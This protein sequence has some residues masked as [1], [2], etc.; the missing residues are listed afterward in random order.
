VS[1]FDHVD[2]TSLLDRK[3]LKWGRHG[4]R[5]LGAWVAEMD[6]ALA[7]EV[8]AALHDAVE[9]GMAGYPLRD[10]S[11]GLP[12]VCAAWLT[13]TYGWQVP[14][15]W[16]FLLPDILAG[17]GLGIDAYSRPGSAVVLPTPAYPPFFE[18]ITARRRRIIEVPIALAGTRSVLDIEGIDAAL[19]S[20][21]GTVL[22]CHPHNPLGRV[23]S[24]A[25]LIALSEVVTARGG[26]VI[27]DEVH[28]P[29]TY[30]GQRHIPYASVSPDA[31]SHTI[32]L[33][34]ASKAWNIAGLKCSQVILSNEPDVRRWREIP[35]HARHGASTLGIAASIA[36][37]TNGN[38]WRHELIGYLDSSRRMLA[39]MLAAE[40][41]DISY[42]PPEATYLAWLDCRQLGLPDPADYFL[43]QARVA[44]SDGAA[45]GAPG[46]GFVR[47]NFATSH[48]ILRRIIRAMSA[49]A[50]GR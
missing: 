25:E 10:M 4:G 9:C 40:L 49:A 46:R 30:P 14:A 18:V 17:V 22:L 42:C 23:F 11:T 21:G 12:S 19:A 26:R 8:R 29:L 47:L 15:E 3:T 41:P 6:F 20:G 38:S 34:S 24:L 43:R 44:L 39:T 13:E 48:A 36:A 31:A 7:P 33:V 35:F 5:V 45:F 37:Y 1:G 2:I 50:G 32:T 27:A 28:A 16:I